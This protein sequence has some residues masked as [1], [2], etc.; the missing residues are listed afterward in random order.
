MRN[1][2][3][4]LAS[5]ILFSCISNICA[6]DWPQ[7]LGPE[8]N[9]TTL[10]KGILRSWPASG[11]E[12]LW[13][14]NVGPGF[15]GPVIKDGKAYL[16]DR[17]E[18]TG[19]IMRCFDFNNGKELWSCSYDAPG[20]F[21][22]PGSRSVPAIDGNRIY[23][24]GPYGDLYCIDINTHKPIWHKNIMK[25]FGGIKIPVWAITQCPLIYND[26]LI[27]SYSKD[28]YAGLVAFNKLT[29]SVTWKT[30][31]FGN[32]TYASPA[33][34][35]IAGEDHIVMVF[36]T[37]NTYMHKEVP[38]SKGR[39][40]G[41]KP[42]TGKILWEYDKW[43]NMVQ[44]APALDAGENRIIIVGGYELGTAMIKV[45]KTAD[46][47]YTV[48]EL[49]RHNDFGD[50]TKPPILYNGYFYAQFSTNSKRDGLCCMSMD[51]KVM[52][53]TIRSPQ[54]D[55]GSMILADGLILATDGRKTLYLIQPDPSGFKPLASAE[56]LGEGQNWGPLALS[57]GKL[58]IRDQ[59]RLMCVKVVK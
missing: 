7:F 29:G 22:Y 11:P 41:V 15:G 10:Q 53:K 6:Q 58:L 35:K 32:E 51:G 56:L 59:N 54:F 50:H 46:G 13:T 36:S 39:V 8:R 31:A 34:V 33:L 2:I 4:L 20:S 42:Q 12:L 44:V 27:V 47:S 24:C 19:D 48:R 30:E 26:L 28:P 18:K 37:T 52:W 45:E 49:F 5:G 14:T 40:I 23:S 21:S 17:D 1:F 38:I 25:D 55:K 3:F 43:E 16:L 9:S 57:N